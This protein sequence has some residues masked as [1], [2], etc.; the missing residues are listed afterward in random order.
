MH[1]IVEFVT[2]HEHKAPSNMSNEL[3]F[4]F[5]AKVC[6]IGGE[7][8]SYIMYMMN[9]RTCSKIHKTKL[10]V[11]MYVLRKIKLNELEPSIMTQT[12]HACGAILH[13]MQFESDKFPVSTT[14]TG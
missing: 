5:A 13:A 3:I 7:K 1:F 6:I 11:C 10:R 9:T 2:V 12:G 4:Y 8:T 14:I